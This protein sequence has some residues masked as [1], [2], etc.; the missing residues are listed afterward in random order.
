MESAASEREGLFRPKLAELPPLQR[1][2]GGLRD[3]DL[4]TALGEARPSVK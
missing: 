4:L 3:S 2:G 1:T